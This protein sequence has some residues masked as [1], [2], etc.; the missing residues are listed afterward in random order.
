MS[1][2]IN[3]KEIMDSAGLKNFDTVRTTIAVAL[4]EKRA[5]HSVYHKE[6]LCK[7]KFDEKK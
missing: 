7:E 5:S 4:F 6:A 2:E 1:D 3:S